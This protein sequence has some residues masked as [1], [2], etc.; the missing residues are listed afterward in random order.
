MVYIYIE[1]DG[2]RV[3]EGWRDP[4][5][6]KE[7]ENGRRNGESVCEWQGERRSERTGDAVG[8]GGCR[9]TARVECEREGGYRRRRKAASEQ[10]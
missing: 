6:Q 2:E 10:R 3:A 8:A 7:T 4:L 9:R 5:G 1:L